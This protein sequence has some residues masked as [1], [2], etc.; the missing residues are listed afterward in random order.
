VKHEVTFVHT[1]NKKGGAGERFSVLWFAFFF[2][3]FF[4]MNTAFVGDLAALV[5]RKLLLLL[6][7]GLEIL[8]LQV[9]F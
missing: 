2:C 4:C 1:E 5:P 8:H 6:E 9:P 7:L 3:C